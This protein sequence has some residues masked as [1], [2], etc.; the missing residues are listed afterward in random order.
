MHACY[1]MWSFVAK[2]QSIPAYLKVI[3]NKEGFSPSIVVSHLH[4]TLL[5]FTVRIILG[6]SDT[7]ATWTISLLFLLI[8]KLNS[9]NDHI[10][11]VSGWVGRQITWVKSPMCTV[12]IYLWRP[13]REMANYFAQVICLFYKMSN[14]Y[15]DHSFDCFVKWATLYMFWILKTIPVSMHWKCIWQTYIFF[16]ETLYLGKK[17]LHG[18]CG[19]LQ[20]YNLNIEHMHIRKFKN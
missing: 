2:V 20:C 12:H 13:L 4:G 1:K 17:T 3:I 14:I 7:E 5:T 6:V 11:L 10:S 9:T 15:N 19:I 18:S 16:V 8:W